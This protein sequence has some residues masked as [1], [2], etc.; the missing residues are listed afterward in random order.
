MANTSGLNSDLE[1]LFKGMSNILVEIMTY[2]T[3]NSS[4]KKNK[5]IS[6]KPQ[7]FTLFAIGKRENEFQK[8]LQFS[9]TIYNLCCQE[10]ITYAYVLIYDKYLSKIMSYSNIYT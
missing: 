7:L 3:Q 6:Y 5:I 1:D 2:I 4:V 8:H 9:F 10:K